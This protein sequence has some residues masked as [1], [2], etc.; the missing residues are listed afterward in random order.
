MLKFAW[1][2]FPVGAMVSSLVQ[3]QQ[4]STE[5]GEEHPSQSICADEAL[6]FLL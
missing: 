3:I 2:D 5:S 6:P 1:T 4:K